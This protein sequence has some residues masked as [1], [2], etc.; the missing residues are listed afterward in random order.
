MS[1]TTKDGSWKGA[2]ALENTMSSRILHQPS[3]NQNIIFSPILALVTFLIAIFPRAALAQPAGWSPWT[4]TNI[5]DIEYHY[6]KRTEAPLVLTEFRND[7][8]KRVSFNY[9][10]WAGSDT[11]TTGCINIPANSTSTGPMIWSLPS[12]VRVELKASSC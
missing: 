3:H 4:A 11:A 10:L 12:R 7:T 8:L 2:S 9:M 5:P 1:Y 6:L